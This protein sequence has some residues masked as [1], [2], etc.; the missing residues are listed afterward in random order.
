MLFF[1]TLEPCPYLLI[2]FSTH[3]FLKKKN[4]YFK[5]ESYQSSHQTETEMA[6]LGKLKSDNTD[7][8]QAIDR[9]HRIWNDC[10]GLVILSAYNYVQHLLT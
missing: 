8:F 2:T 5:P 1:L 6:Y 3:A 4:D 9:R 7:I 10:V